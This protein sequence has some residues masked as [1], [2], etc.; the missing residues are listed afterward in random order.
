MK[1]EE[2]KKAEKIG[3]K[4]GFIVMYFIFTT[5]IYLILRLSKKI[6]E[7]WSYIHII[8]LTFGIIIIGGI[9]N[10]ILK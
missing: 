1:F 4:I 7:N 9:L 2:N 3:E 10:K 8:I 5:F 6:P